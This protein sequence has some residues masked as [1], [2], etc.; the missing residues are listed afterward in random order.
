MSGIIDRLSQIWRM[1]LD[2]VG[3]F[4]FKDLLDVIIIAMLVY[5]CIKLIRETRAGQLVKGLAL[6]VIAYIVADWLDMVMVSGLLAQFMTFAVVA[7]VILFQPEIRKAL[8]Q[9]GR[10]NMRRTITGFFTGRDKVS[11]DTILINAIDNI[12]D[13]AA[14]LQK[15]QTGALIVFE[16]NTNLS[17]IAQSGTIIDADAESQLIG[18][19]FYNKAPLH[20]GAMII[21]DGRILAAGCILPLTSRKNVNADLGTRHRAA[22]GIS[23]DSDAIALVVSEETGQISL[24]Q[25]G[26]LTRNYSKAHLKETLEEILLLKSDSEESNKGFFGRFKRNTRKGGTEDVK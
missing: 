20:D 3:Q 25:N 15:T 5:G 22:L 26:V 10:N 23:E 11:G 7:L 24:A 14:D 2:I 6:L 19:I 16:R 17:E 1:I 4:E 12:V 13:A 18:N 8:E 9:M 21:R